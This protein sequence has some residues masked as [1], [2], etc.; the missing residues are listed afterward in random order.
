M[1]AERVGGKPV[2]AMIFAAGFGSRMRP[3]TDHT[4]KP[5]LKVAGKPLIEY[6]LEALAKAD[7]EDVVIN[8]SHLGEQIQQALGGGERWGLNIQYSVEPTPQETLGGL[9]RALP[10]LD[11]DAFFVVNADVFCDVN[12]RQVESSWRNGEALGHL[13]LAPNPEFHPV[14]DFA[15]DDDYLSN[16]HDLQRFTFAGVSLLTRELLQNAECQNGA[17]APLLRAAADKKQLTASVHQ[18]YWFDVGTPE[19]LAEVD[20]FAAAKA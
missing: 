13:L 1:Q 10:L 20:A 9:I 17:L 2:K 15:I 8:V 4:P 18:G 12:W 11:S 7:V 5:L 3:L 6:H 16:S 19:R 14:G